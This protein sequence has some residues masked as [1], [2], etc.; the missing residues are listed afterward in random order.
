MKETWTY[1]KMF[2]RFPVALRRFLREPLTLPRAQG[3]V[4][5]RMEQRADNFLRVVERAVYGHRKSPYL[6]LLRH[7]GCELGDLRALVRERGLEGALAELGAAGVYVTFEEFKGRRPIV[8]GGLELRVKPADFDN[9][10]A[11]H[12]FAVRTGGSTGLSTLVGQDLDH[13]AAG[14]PMQMLM[15]DAYGL[16]DTPTAHWIQIFPGTGLRFLLQRAYFRQYSEHWYSSMGW[17][18]SKAWPKYDLATLYMISCAR[19]LGLQLPFPEIVRRDEA[20]VVARWV[21]DTLAKRGRCFLSTHVSPAVRVAVA[22]QEAG[23]DLSGATFRV[24]GEPVTPAKARLME[25]SGVRVVPA[26]GMVEISTV[27]LG[28]P[29]GRHADDVHLAM[30]TVALVTHPHPVDGTGVTVPAFRITTLTDTVTKL[31]LNVQVDD[32]GVV[33]ES[34]CGCPLE[35]HGFT[36]HLHDIRSYS[37]LL[38]EGVTLIGNDMLHI[39]EHVLPARFGGTALDYQLSEEEDEESLTRL[40]LVVSPRVVVRDEGELVESLLE[41][42]RASSPAAGV[43]GTVWRQAQTI[44]VKRAEPAW[45][46]RGKLLPLHIQSRRVDGRSGNSN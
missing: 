5:A 18:D 15:L 29:N 27:G 41:A 42:L 19:L 40:Y 16:L 23:L 26:Y 37:K 31:M 1:A 6:A 17:T 35:A 11:R 30:D 24:G 7:A 45:T 36:V 33:D 12:D 43:A 28:C 13:I 25:K 20:I 8:R 44:R 4:R 22:A 21:H 3:I 46:A 9:P 14:A 2:A 32:Y 38:G 10:S 34:P 39:L